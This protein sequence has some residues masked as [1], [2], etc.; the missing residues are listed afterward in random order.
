MKEE[1]EKFQQVM[2]D[3]EIGKIRVAEKVDGQWRVNSWI[4]EVILSGFRLGQ[5]VDMSL[6]GYAFFDK[7]TVPT[8]KFTAENGV[9]IV[10]GGSAIR[11]GA[12]L[13]PSVIVMPPSYV[14]IGAYVD[15]DTMIDSHALVG[16]CAQVGKHVHLS[17]A[18]QLGGVLE[19][20]G[21]LPVIIED[22]VFIGGN[23]GIY[24]GTIVKENAVIGTGVIINKST[25]LFDATT[26]EYISTNDNGQVVVPKGAV[27]VAGSRPIMHG[28]GASKGI[29]LYTP[30]IVKYR[31]E[32]TSA[33]IILEDLLR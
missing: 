25:A 29:H 31:D 14:N 16:S 28:P 4:K 13:A 8:R 27:V 6:C 7:D 18:S 2:H 19:P 23:C 20:V 21:A 30:I 11:T 32:K 3:L 15:S 24:E 9:R 1:L 22:N 26:G 5:L 33:S 10:P 17:A 12:Y